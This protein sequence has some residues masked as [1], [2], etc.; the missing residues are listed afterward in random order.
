MRRRAV[1]NIT[2]AFVGFVIC[3]AVASGSNAQPQKVVQTDFRFDAATLYDN[4]FMHM[5]M[6]DPGGVRLFNRE[7]I[8]NDSPGAGNSEKGVWTDTVLGK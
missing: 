2:R 1:K 8:Q 5:L 3:L 6:R 7:V 4:G